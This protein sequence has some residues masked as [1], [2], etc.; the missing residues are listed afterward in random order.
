MT[1]P[2]R[3]TSDYSDY[4]RQRNLPDDKSSVSQTGIL[5]KYFVLLEKHKFLFFT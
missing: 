5:V 4:V 3:I 1:E 2:G